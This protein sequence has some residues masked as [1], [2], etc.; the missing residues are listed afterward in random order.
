MKAYRERCAVQDAELEAKDA[1]HTAALEAKDAAHAEELDTVRAT[2]AAEMDAKEVG[3][4]RH[5]VA[6]L[7]VGVGRSAWAAMAPT[8]P[9]EH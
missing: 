8:P 9:P 3:N 4:T 1:T 2:H 6:I 7:G 5:L